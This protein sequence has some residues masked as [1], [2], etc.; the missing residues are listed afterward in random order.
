MVHVKR[1][2][3]MSYKQ[4][5][6]E[7]NAACKLPAQA[8]GALSPHSSFLMPRHDNQPA[9]RAFVSPQVSS[10]SSPN[11]DSSIKKVQYSGRLPSYIP[12]DE[13]HRLIAQAK[14]HS[15]D[16]AAGPQGSKTP[17]PGFAGIPSFSGS[18]ANGFAGDATGAGHVA[19][20]PVRSR[21]ASGRLPVHEKK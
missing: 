9:T 13:Q 11:G 2:L 17:P 5:I 7:L 8:C 19:P 18:T 21:Q 3:D 4:E 14:L 20:S 15:A 12:P 16:A 6:A 1:D 10:Q